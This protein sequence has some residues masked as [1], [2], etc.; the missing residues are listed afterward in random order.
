MNGGSLQQKIEFFEYELVPNGSGG[1]IPGD[2]V[3][4]LST[5][6][7]IRQIKASRTAEALQTQLNSVY[8]MKL[9]KRNGFDP[10][11]YQELKWRDENYA[12]IEVVEDV[13]DKQ[14]WVLTVTGRGTGLQD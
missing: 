14:Y 13:K 11:T 8:E 6:A 3:L 7:Q 2:P 10:K 5:F 4:K 9:R 12:I 1:F